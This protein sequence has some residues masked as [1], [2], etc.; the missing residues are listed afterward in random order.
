MKYLTFFLVQFSAVI[1]HYFASV[2]FEFNGLN[3]GDNFATLV[4]QG[5]KTV[6]ISTTLQRSDTIILTFLCWLDSRIR[7]F[8]FLCSFH[9]IS[10]VVTR[11][12]YLVFYCPGYNFESLS[13]PSIIMFYIVLH[14]LKL[15][16]GCQTPSCPNYTCNLGLP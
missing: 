14:M 10:R 5:I 11:A 7:G 2:L 4:R 15:Y 16:F 9:F 6:Y 13:L 3:Q 1:F 8:I 12:K